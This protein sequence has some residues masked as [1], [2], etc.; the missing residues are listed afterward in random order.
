[1]QESGSTEA[2]TEEDLRSDGMFNA[3]NPLVMRQVASMAGGGALD[4]RMRDWYLF[5]RDAIR[6]DPFSISLEPE[7]LAAPRT[8]ENKQGHCVH[9]SILLVAGFRAM[10]VPARL[11]L[12]KVRNHLATES[13]ERKLGTDV[14]TPHGYAAFWNGQRWIKCTPVFNRSLCDRLG[15]SVLDW[16]PSRDVLFQPLDSRGGRFMEY[17]ED[18]GL[19]A[20]VP[21]AF[22]RS[23]LEGMYPHAFDAEGRWCLKASD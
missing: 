21:L 5:V 8:L 11:G 10:G 4:D 7:D 18:F 17:L 22:M 2:P 13:L 23:Q 6:Y 3:A 14:L 15:T 16:D 19:H 20:T 1:M 9:K 12:A